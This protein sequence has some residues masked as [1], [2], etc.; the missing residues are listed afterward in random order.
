MF[1]LLFGIITL[2]VVFFIAYICYEIDRWYKRTFKKNCFNCKHW[3]L[4]NVPSFGDGHEYRCKKKNC[5]TKPPMITGWEWW[6]K[7]DD[8]DSKD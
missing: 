8:Y 3:Y 5:G 2:I 7:C 4:H 1:Q 6:V